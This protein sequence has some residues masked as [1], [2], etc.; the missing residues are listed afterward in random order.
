M[1]L[2]FIFTF[3]FIL[4][5]LKYLYFIYFINLFTCKDKLINSWNYSFSSEN[6]ASNPWVLATH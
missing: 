3:N 2:L 4:V 1:I 6:L 5:Y